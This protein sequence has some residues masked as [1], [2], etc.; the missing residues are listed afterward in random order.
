MTDTRRTSSE[1]HVSFKFESVEETLV[2]VVDR[3]TRNVRNI[4][5]DVL[6]KGS[7]SILGRQ[8]LLQR[9]KTCLHQNKGGTKMIFLYAFNSLP[10]GDKREQARENVH[11]GIPE[12]IALAFPATL[13]HT[14]TTL[15][16]RAIGVCLGRLLRYIPQTF[17]F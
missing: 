17:L 11:V 15:P 8:I 5:V 1:L 3:T 2:K 13:A 12:P 7:T 16:L 14:S 4:S 10:A 6:S 9:I